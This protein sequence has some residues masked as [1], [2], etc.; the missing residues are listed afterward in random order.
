MKRRIRQ[1]WICAVVLIISGRNDLV[2]Q[3]A[4]DFSASVTQGCAPQL[5]KFTDL[6]T[7]AAGSWSWD[8]G[9]GATSTLQN[10][11]TVYTQP[12]VY[13][14]SLTVNGT[15]GSGTETKTAYITIFEGPKADFSVNKATACELENFAFTDLSTAGDAAITTYFWDFGDGGSSATQNPQHGYTVPGNK[16]V[17]LRVTDANGCESF[18]QKVNVLTVDPKPDLAFTA[19]KPA[20]CIVPHT[21]NFS[22]NQSS[23]QVSYYWDFGNG[24]NAST[25]TGSA[26]YT[27]PGSYTVIL[28]GENT[29]TGCRDTLEKTAYI[30]VGNYNIDFNPSKA[31]GCNNQPID[32]TL[33][34]SG[35]PQSVLWDFGDGNLGNTA[36]AQNTYAAPGTYT[37]KLIA[38][39]AG[40]CKDSIIKTLVIDDEPTPNYSLNPDKSCQVPFNVTFVN[41]TPGNGSFWE[42][43]DGDTSSQ[44][45]TIHTYNTQGPF[46]IKFTSISPGGC[47]A[48]QIDTID[49]HPEIEVKPSPRQVC[50]TSANV[51]FD[52][53]STPGNPTSFSWDFDD[54]NTSS[55]AKPSHFFNGQGQYIVKLTLT[56]PGGCTATGQDTVSIFSKPI[57]DF[58][59]DKRDTCVKITI[60]FTNKSSN[61]T[62]FEWDFGDGGIDSINVNPTHK[63]KSWP[64]ILELPD[65][66]DIKLTLWNGTCQADT[67]ITSYINIDPPLAW[68]E[69]NNPEG[70]FCDTPAVV[71]FSDVSRYE[72]PRDTVLRVWYFNDPNAYKVNFQQCTTDTKNNVNVGRNCN[73]SVDSLPT[74]TYSQFGNYNAQLWLFSHRT[75][76]FD[77]ITYLVRVR[78]KFKADFT[79]SAQSGCAPL[80]VD[81]E[82]TTSRSVE[83]FWDFGDLRIDG[84]TDIVRV[85]EYEYP[86]P[87]KYYP[88]LFATDADG[89]L[90]IV[91]K[92]IDV[93]G[94]R[95]SFKTGG[96]LCPPDTVSFFDISQKTDSLVSWHWDFGDAANTQPDT[97]SQRHPRFRFSGPGNYLVT[98]LVTDNLGC[99]N[100]ITRILEYAPPVPEF[101]VIPD[102]ICVNNAVNMQNYTKGGFT[103]KYHW[104]FGDGDTSNLLNPAH[105]YADTGRYDVFLRVQRADGCVDSLLME[106]GVRV[107]DP[108]VD[109]SANKNQGLCPPFT[110]V[111]TSV[112]SDDV[113]EYYW[114]FGDSSNS[115]QSNPI[116][117]YNEPGIYTVTLRVKSIGGCSD[118]VIKVDY[119]EVGGPKG[120]FSF[121]PKQGCQPLSVNFKADASNVSVYTWDFGDGEVIH[122]S[123]D[124]LLHIYNSRGVFKP[125]LILTDSNNCSATLSS[126]DSIISNSLANANLTLS[127]P[128]VCVGGSINFTDISSPAAAIRARSWELD[129][130]ASGN[131]TVY[132]QQ[133]NDTGEFGV[134]LIVTDTLGCM[135]DTLV[136]VQVQAMPVITISNDTAVCFGN[137]VQL[138]VS[139]GD[140]YQWSP[141]TGL[142]NDTLPDPYAQPLNTTTY[143]VVVK[144]GSACPDVSETVEVTI[145]PLPP[146]DAGPDR[147]IC[148][149]DSVLLVATGAMDYLWEHSPNLRDTASDSTWVF[150]GVDEYFKVYGTDSRG[151]SY[152][153][154]VLVSPVVAPV[155]VIEG[156]SE[157]CYGAEV[158]LTAEGGNQFQWNTGETTKSI[159]P[160][161]YDSQK[162]WVESFLD[163]CFGG[164]DTT[165]IEVD[166]TGFVADFE[167]GK[168]SIYA[169]ELLDL[170]NKTQLAS[171]FTWF[172]GDGRGAVYDSL[173]Q[174]A[175]SGEG[176]YRIL[177]IARS[178][179]GCEDSVARWLTVLP[180]Y[181]YFPNAFTPNGDLLNDLYEYFFPYELEEARLRIYDR[182]GE[183]IFESTDQEHMWDGTYRGVAV[184]DGVYMYLF[185]GRKYSGQRINRKG[186]I[187]LLR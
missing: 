174:F 154:S 11:S 178:H 28:Y 45:N 85:T 14:V 19:D 49:F 116:H 51:T 103:N 32:F 41:N 138:M 139:G 57:P 122:T 73:Y 183:L 140:S 159:R 3:I 39:F 130:V 18:G 58:E 113:S 38:S 133:F 162:F 177:L 101:K 153:D 64:K 2:G 129:N 48:T 35:T 83:W 90:A 37:V 50:G 143:T 110:V 182:W 79:V 12:G 186:T 111:F 29:T 17:S 43:G 117:T 105:T 7:P 94:P 82:D 114:D 25:T 34:G 62:A 160:R 161:L 104:R 31:R 13:T 8:F 75:R 44:R 55:Q 60:N 100:S 124:S 106:K 54:G 146:I 92:E 109:F 108:E 97:T 81:F 67:T 128:K 24:S 71:N 30:Q 131:G 137:R 152:Y 20:S 176:Q 126:G 36:P 107:V 87:G 61:Y 21:V 180:D 98:L 135:D 63:Y 167:L 145:W 119:I 88:R 69:T 68:I 115:T 65:S 169:G 16:T 66:F 181:H 96:R 172:A 132:Q 118:S 185:M 76:C 42:F 155:P 9:N 74:H 147:K 15:A 125:V 170:L 89:C 10:P 134:R 112:A 80:H 26:T 91:D 158:V 47:E 156:P 6:S 1:Y 187:T 95:A 120:T 102:V 59:A 52:F 144:N 70:L 33:S 141:S 171:H 165:R 123:D 53:E 175:Y 148:I 23:S 173:P 142:S 4:A 127:Q 168:D 77:S 84:D 22:N 72:N 150:P 179:N 78:P 164:T 151:C 99:S 40:G 157:V 27:S 121:D 56:Y 136:Q 86:L 93:R 46:I 166:V 149:G 163:G 184:P 5:V